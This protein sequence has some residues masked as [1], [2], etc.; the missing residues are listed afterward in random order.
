MKLGRLVVRARVP[1]ARAI[2]IPVLGAGDSRVPPSRGA[3]LRAETM[4]SLLP[5]G[6]D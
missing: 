3:A 1:I 5:V 4:Y 6:P 2:H